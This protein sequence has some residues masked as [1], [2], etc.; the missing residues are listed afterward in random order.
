MKLV[1]MILLSLLALGNE[2]K[3]PTDGDKLKVRE[4]QL[5][6][7]AAYADVM[8][9]QVKYQQAVA[10]QASAIADLGKKLGCE[11]DPQTIECKAKPSETSSK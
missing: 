9:A 3:K 2:P 11:I 6:T 10:V 4:A 8:A 7:L 1:G 5:A